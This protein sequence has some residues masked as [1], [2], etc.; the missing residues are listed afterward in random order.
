MHKLIY[1]AWILV[2]LYMV[3]ELVTVHAPLAV[4]PP[5]SNCY[6]PGEAHSADAIPCITIDGGAQ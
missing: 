5:Q 3:A 1:L 6:I 4:A 2:A